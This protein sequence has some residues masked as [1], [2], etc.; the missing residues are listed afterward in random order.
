MAY[1]LIAPVQRLGPAGPEAA[2][3]PDTEGLRGK[4]A[5][6][7]NPP[8]AGAERPQ[9]AEEPRADGPEG[10]PRPATDGLRNIRLHFKIDP[11][12]EELTVLMVDTATQRV[13]RTIPPDELRQ[14]TQGD[15][16]EVLT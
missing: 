16:V 1:D 15:L 9:A 12:T 4:A 13:V 6:P 5:S 2:A 14:M 10:R 8:A 3:R 7:A 11:K